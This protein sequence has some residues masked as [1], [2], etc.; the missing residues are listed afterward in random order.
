LN[1]FID[2]DYTL[3]SANGALR[4]H[5]QTLFNRLTDAGHAMYIWSGVGIRKYEMTRHKID[6][7]VTDYFE[8]PTAD[9]RAAVER[10]ALPIAPDLVVDDHEEIV[11]E[12][13]GVVV[14]PYFFADDS[15]KE[16]VNVAD[17][18][19]DYAESGTSSFSRF[20]SPRNGAG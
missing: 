12:F 7:M 5:A 10:A 19:L 13:G 14:R 8:K 6:P 3:I 17:A 2:V 16:L 11:H 15:D 9:Y 4:P 1:F 20:V 18:L